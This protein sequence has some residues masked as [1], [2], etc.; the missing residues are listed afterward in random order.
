VIPADGGGSSAPSPTGPQTLKVDPPAIPKARDA[1]LAASKEIQDLVI[2][3]KGTFTPAWA[4]D[5]VSRQT[6]ERFDTG[7]GDRGTQPAIAALEKYG[8][9]LQGSGEALHQAYLA[10]VRNE[11]VNSER[12]RGQDVEA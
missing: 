11:G 1:F 12:W 8:L 9:E 5:P 4:N 7:A 6:A 2:Q 3:L 10:Y